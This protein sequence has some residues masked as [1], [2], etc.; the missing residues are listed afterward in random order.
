MNEKKTTVDWAKEFYCSDTI[1]KRAVSSS[2]GDTKRISL[3]HDEN[4]PSFFR[5]LAWSPDGSFV[6]IPSGIYREDADAPEVHTAYLYA[7][8]KWSAPIAH[9]PGQTKPV[10]A[11]R[12]C[13]LIFQ[14][15][16]NDS[17]SNVPQPFENLPYK[18]VYAV[19]TLDSVVL[20]DTSSSLPLAAFCQ[21]HYDS[22]SDIAWS[23]DGQYLAVSSRDCFCS[24]VSFEEGELGK[25]VDV[26]ALPQHI[27]EVVKYTQTAWTRPESREEKENAGNLDTINLIEDCADDRSP[28]VMD[29]AVK[30]KRIVPTPVGGSVA[31]TPG[32]IEQASITNSTTPP[33][34]IQVSNPPGSKDKKK[35]I[36]PQPVTAVGNIAAMAA[37]AGQTEANGV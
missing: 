14:N 26:L 3:F 19:A 28:P 17:Q 9:V 8:G 31:G 1:N 29:L 7:R 30:R 21:I 13:P 34:T 11:V 12:F 6:V 36:T 22:I 27:Q 5:R 32:T 20:Y 24:I 23:K 35:R 33:T 10:V 25:P 2:D 4:L 16:S 15:A 18:L 37:L